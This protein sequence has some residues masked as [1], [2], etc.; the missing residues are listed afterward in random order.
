[1][2]R[3]RAMHAYQAIILTPANDQC[4]TQ[5]NE[6]GHLPN[7]LF[8]CGHLISLIGAFPKFA[9]AWAWDKRRVYSELLEANGTK[10]PLAR[11]LQLSALLRR[12]NLEP[13]RSKILL[14]DAPE[15]RDSR[16]DISTPRLISAFPTRLFSVAPTM[17]H[18][19]EMWCFFN[20]SSCGVTHRQM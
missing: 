2:T 10:L 6:R 14:E 15:E 4:K 17:R 18:D 19:A 1:M 12:V 16:S 8:Y 20:S 3:R 5:W 7:G 9:D 11:Q 13:R